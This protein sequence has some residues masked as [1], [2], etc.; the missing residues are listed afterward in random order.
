MGEIEE[1]GVLSHPVSERVPFHLMES[2]HRGHSVYRR[3]RQVKEGDMH[4]LDQRILGIAI[5][6]ILGM[7]VIVKRAATGSIL[8]K[9]KGE[10]LVQLV[11]AFNIFFILIVNPISAILLIAGLLPTSDPTHIVVS[12]RGIAVVLESVGLVLY[13][14]GFLLMAWA[15]IT[16]GHNYQLGGSTPR[17]DDQ[18]V[19]DGPYRLVRHPMYS[20]ALSIS[21][22][23]FLLMQSWAF[24]VVFLVYLALIIPLIPMEENALETAY[25]GRYRVYQDKTRRI[26]PFLY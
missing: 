19:V 1:R 22:A 6:L 21:L 4:L 18:M 13:M 5:L 10:F 17:P 3:D 2:E 15:L 11:N 24:L 12:E 16:L 25:N 20:A 7:L 23:F 14:M 8:D 9:P 26:V